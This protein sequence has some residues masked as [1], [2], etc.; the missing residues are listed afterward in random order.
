M[1]LDLGKLVG[2]QIWNPPEIKI[3]EQVSDYVQSLVW[4]QVEERVDPVMFKL[5]L[6]FFDLEVYFNAE[7]KFLER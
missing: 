6:I 4:L 7:Q 3:N 2:G 5:F 1:K